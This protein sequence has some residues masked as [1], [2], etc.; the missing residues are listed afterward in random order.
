MA[1]TSDP[2][3]VGTTT[4]SVPFILGTYQ[5]NPLPNMQGPVVI[6]ELYAQFTGAAAIATFSII[7]SGVGV[8][9]A[10]L[11]IAT[12]AI[13]ADTIDRACSVAGELRGAQLNGGQVVL[14]YQV[15]TTDLAEGAG[16]ATFAVTDSQIAAALYDV[17]TQ[18]VA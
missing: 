14:S 16:T 18:R 1:T 3:A 11:T 12:V 8:V 10:P 9:G 4:I 6:A 7:A 15:I 13:E 2:T 5:I 17:P